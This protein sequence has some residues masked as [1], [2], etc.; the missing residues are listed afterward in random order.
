MHGMVKMGHK[1]NKRRGGGWQTVYV[2]ST[3]VVGFVVVVLMDQA[4]MPHR[5]RA[6]VLGTVL[7]FGFVILGFRQRLFSMDVLDVLEYLLGCAFDGY[8]VYF[9]HIARRR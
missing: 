6:A 4:G 5:W 3:A 8:M 7:P 9:P 1:G 2:V